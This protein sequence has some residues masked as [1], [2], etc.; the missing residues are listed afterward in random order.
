[1]PIHGKKIRAKSSPRTNTPQDPSMA[2]WKYIGPMLASCGTVRT[3]S[4]ASLSTYS[5]TLLTVCQE[6]FEKK[7][8]MPNTFSVMELTLCADC[9]SKAIGHCVHLAKS[10][11]EKFSSTFFKRWRGQGREALVAL[12][13]E[14]NPL[15]VRKTQER[16]NFFAEQRKRENPRRGFSFQCENSIFNTSS[17]T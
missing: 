4:S 9:S 14:R 6:L 12:R 3:E 5:I 16:V 13:R 15:I 1:M 11:Q 10:D 17:V 7:L 2:L 8:N